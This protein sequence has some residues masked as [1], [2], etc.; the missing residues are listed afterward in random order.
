MQFLTGDYD[1]DGRDDLATLNHQADGTV[2]MWTWTARPDAMFNG[3]I[4]GW[5][6]P[7]S[8]WVFGSA[9]FFTTYPKS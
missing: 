8:S 4:A 1:G 7:A 5:S 6:A 9:Q 3:G 2:K